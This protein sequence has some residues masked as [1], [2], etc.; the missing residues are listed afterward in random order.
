MNEILKLL[1]GWMTNIQLSIPYVKTSVMQVT[2]MD[3]LFSLIQSGILEGISLGFVYFSYRLFKWGV[4]IQKAADEYDDWCI[5]IY[6]AASLI[7]IISF[8]AIFVNLC[9]LLDFW[10]WVGVNHP[11]LYLIHKAVQLVV[12]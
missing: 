11:D 10:T 4:K 2:S 8:V 9:A 6:I 7:F 12:H 1:A 3:C 5:P